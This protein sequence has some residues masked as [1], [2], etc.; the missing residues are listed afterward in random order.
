MKAS[1]EIITENISLLERFV[2]PM[3]KMMK[4]GFQ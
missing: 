2:M 1:A 3:K 4:E